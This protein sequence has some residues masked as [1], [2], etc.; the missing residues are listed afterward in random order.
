ME[1]ALKMAGI[2]S[3]TK[4]CLHMDGDQSD[5]NHTLTT[6]GSPKLNSTTKKFGASSMYFDGEDCYISAP[7]STDW[8]FANQPMTIDFWVNFSSLSGSQLIVNQFND[9]N[10]HWWLRWSSNKWY[11]YAVSGGGAIAQYWGPTVSLATDTWYHVAFVRNGTS[12]LLFQ[13]GVLQT[14]SSIPT[15]IGSSHLPNT[16]ALLQIGGDYG[17]YDLH[18]YLD[19]LRIT[20]NEAR[21][22]TGFTPPTSAYTTDANTKLLLHFNGDESDSAHEVTFYGAPQINATTAKFDGAYYFDG[23]SYLSVPDS[24]DWAFG[25]GSFTIDCWVNATA[26]IGHWQ[27]IYHQTDN[28][29]YQRFM[30]NSVNIRF[31]EY[32][33]LGTVIEGTYSMN[34]GVWYHLA[35]VRNVNSWNIYIDGVSLVNTTDTSTLS[36][37]IGDLEIGR[38]TAGTADYFT[39]YIDELRISKGIARWTENFDVPTE[40]YT[41]APT[42]AF[43]VK[44]TRSETSR[45]IVFDESD[46]SIEVNTVVS[47]S[48]AYEVET[49]DTGD[50]TIIARASDGEIVGY[51][52]ITPIEE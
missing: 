50:R 48:G 29:K 43:K 9:A 34:T 2:D 14:W 10:N 52:G 36:N 39:G 22:T 20:R 7:D 11:F 31:D 19:E 40:A 26:I 1:V 13:D 37:I 24:D 28:S 45:I 6:V 15:A 49:T 17:N 3:Y 38:E 35:L 27:C 46:W 30:Y 12:L 21:W 18:G 25:N 51:G 42:T 4:L 8:S 47:G 5:S 44:G 41:E 33:G 23:S 16:S 32:G